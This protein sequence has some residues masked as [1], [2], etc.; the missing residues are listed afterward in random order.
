MFDIF[1]YILVLNKSFI[2]LINIL[3]FQHYSHQIC[4]QL[5]SILCQRNRLRACYVMLCYV[6][7]LYDVNT[8]KGCRYITCAN[9][10]QLACLYRI[11]AISESS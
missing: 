8:P 1:H 10:L 9:S 2:M 3:F 6:N 4:S 5:F 11:L 7:K